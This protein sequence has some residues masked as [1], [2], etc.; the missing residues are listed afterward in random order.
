MKKIFLLFAILLFALSGYSQS[1]K[2]VGAWLLRD[3]AESM[4][5]LFKRDGTIEERRGLVNEDIWNKEAKTGKYTLTEKGKLVITWAGNTIENREVK[6]LDNFRNA[7]IR[8]SNKKNNQK[9]NYLFLRIVD[10]EVLP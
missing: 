4:H 5:I 10:E 6:F 1:D 2:I 3:S 8:F 9:K 7:H